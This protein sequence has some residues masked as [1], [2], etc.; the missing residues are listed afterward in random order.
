MLH[1]LLKMPVVLVVC[2]GVRAWH[3]DSRQLQCYRLLAAAL[4]ILLGSAA[5]AQPPEY[6]RSGRSLA[7]LLEVDDGPGNFVPGMP[8]ATID[9]AK[10][11]AAGIRK[12]AGRRLILFTDL[13]Y[14]P[15]IEQLPEVFEQ[16]FPAW[17][18]YFGIDPKV[19]PTWHMTGFLMK[20]GDRFRRAGLLPAMLP[21][22]KNGFAVNYDLWL[23]EQPTAYYRR[24]LLL[25]EGTHGFMNTVLRSCGPP[26]YMEGMAEL[27]GTHRW[28]DGQLALGVIPKSRDDVPMWGRV[29]KI[30]DLFVQDQALSFDQVVGFRVSAHQHNEAYAWSW[31]IAAFLDHHPRYRDRFRAMS[32]SVEA[33][34][35][36]QK[37]R[38]MIA[39]DWE[40]VSE[41]WQLFVAGIEYGYDVP[42]MAIDFSPGA[43]PEPKWNVARVDSEVGWQNSGFRLEAG[44]NYEI[45]A[46][47]RYEIAR[48]PAS[49]ASATTDDKTPVAPATEPIWWCEPGGV[50][51]RYYRGL[52]LGM[53]VAAVRPEQPTAKASPLL[54]PLSVGLG[55]VLRPKLSGTLF[56]RINDSA[57]ELAENAGGLDVAIR[58]VAEPATD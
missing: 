21:A 20:D 11:S 42:R 29:R 12:I 15:E 13:P 19:H 1:K 7:D 31:A 18:E 34:D 38:Q 10:A 6:E 51:I 56:L 53:L 9:E 36:N 4:L 35:F 27:L 33:R 5:L 39:D 47:G 50:T 55:T 49:R 37:F 25:H 16:A 14:D 28:K 48:G 46:R 43:A 22:F 30:Q 57:A 52:P 24:H 3:P 40:H 2:N 23:Y 44:T 41:E 17:C 58:P 32:R 54:E 8:R 45:R 26:W